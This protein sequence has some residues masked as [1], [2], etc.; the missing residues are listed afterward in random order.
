VTHAKDQLEL[1]LGHGGFGRLERE[2]RFHPVRKWRADYYLAD[3]VPPV[4]VE[5]DGLMHHGSNQ[6]HASISGILRDSEKINAATAMGIRVYRANAK[7]I[8]DG[9]FFR[10]MDDVL[11]VLT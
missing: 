8:G 11:E 4:I 3:Q 9:S 1:Y 5:Y 7:S 2:Y 6:G 10:L